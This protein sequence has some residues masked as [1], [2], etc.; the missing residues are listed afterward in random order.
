MESL[1]LPGRYITTNY[2]THQKPFYVD[3]LTQKPLNGDGNRHED[4]ATH[5]DVSKRIDKVGECNCEDVTAGVEA[6]ECVV[7]TPHYDVDNIETG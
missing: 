6:S 4:G 5:G 1:G 2:Q 3:E 7:E